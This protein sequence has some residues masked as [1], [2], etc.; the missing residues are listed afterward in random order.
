MVLWYLGMNQSRLV[1]N[2]R[3]HFKN[4]ARHTAHNIVSWPKP[5]QRLMIHMFFRKHSV[6]V[7][8]YQ[9]CQV[10]LWYYNDILGNTIVIFLYKHGWTIDYWYRIHSTLH[11]ISAVINSLLL[12]PISGFRYHDVKRNLK[13]T[14]VLIT[15][16][17][18][19]GS[20]FISIT[21]VHDLLCNITSTRTPFTNMI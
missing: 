6:I 8:F 12:L 2:D 1:V 21:V 16:M 15:P 7:C 3:P 9:K 5:K 13:L 17:R 11:T 4:I 10:S 18:I 20:I 19:I 14:W